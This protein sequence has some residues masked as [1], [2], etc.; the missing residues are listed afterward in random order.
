[1]QIPEF[2]PTF[3]MGGRKFCA[4]SMVEHHKRTI[5]ALAMSAAPPEYEEPDVEEFVPVT[6]VAK[7]LGVSRRTIGRRMANPRNE[8][9]EAA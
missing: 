4:R 8:N 7:E 2:P 1:M 5:V 6:Q 3:E 9:G